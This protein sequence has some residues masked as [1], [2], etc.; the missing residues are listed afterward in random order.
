MV[1]TVHLV[2]N[3]LALDAKNEYF[4]Y[5]RDEIP[6]VFHTDSQS[7]NFIVVKSRNRKLLQQITLPL[8]SRRDHLDVMFFPYNSAAIFPPCR[9]VVTIHDLHPYVIAHRFSLVH[10]PDVQGGRL[11][12][13]VNKLYWKKML[14]AACKRMDRIIAVSNSTKRDIVD[15]FKIPASSI[16]VVHEGVDTSYFNVECNGRDLASFQ[17]TYNL[18]E[19]YILCVGTH[20]YK[21]IEGAIKAFS[22]I[23]GHYDNE[24]HLVVTGKKSYLGREVPELVNALQLEPHVVFTDF[25]PDKDLKYLYQ[26]ADVFLFPSFYEGFGLPVL[27]AFA[28]GTPVV[29]SNK[30]SLPEVAGD[31]ALLA[32]PKNPQQ[33]AKAVLRLLNDREFRDEQTR[34]GFEQVKRF[35]WR[36]AA[37]QTYDIFQQVVLSG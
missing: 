34:R 7:A 18:P 20:A 24:I 35:S 29:T 16:S 33:I 31:A 10:G 2:N 4:I 21:N 14:V 9:G 28:C 8:R 3:L 32:D 25:F 13:V 22:I 5:C 27:E 12:S 26:G 15:I 30:G 36:K 1:Y 11:R 6:N 19:R 23:H 37:S 17:K